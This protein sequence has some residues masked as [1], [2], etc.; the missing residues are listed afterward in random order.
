M[1]VK[2]ADRIKA[3]FNDPYGQGFTASSRRLALFL[4]VRVPELH[5]AMGC[6]EGESCKGARCN[7]KLGKRR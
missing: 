4:G 2:L 3:A 1:T 7:L 5:S 6:P